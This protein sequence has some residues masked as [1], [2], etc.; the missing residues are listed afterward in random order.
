MEEQFEHETFWGSNWVV[1]FFFKTGTSCS[2]F[3]FSSWLTLIESSPMLFVGE[4]E[5]DG[6]L[7]QNSSSYM[8]KHCRVMWVLMTV[9]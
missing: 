6:I 5:G 4:D 8:L 1:L 9:S 7:I 3:E 2:S